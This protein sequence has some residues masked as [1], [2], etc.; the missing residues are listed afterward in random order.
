MR[1]LLT[2]VLLVATGV[3]TTACSS[4]GRGVRPG[5]EVVTTLEVDNQNFTDMTIYLVNGGQ[6]IRLGRATGKSKT[7][8]RLPRN[9][10]TFPRE[11]QFSAEPLG[12]QPGSSTSRIWV[13]P[14]DTVLL[15]ITP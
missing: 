14:G 3:I 6:R 5:S 15:V 12:G 9:V 11:L 7:A 2:L 8:M 13:N 10:L 4:G 1:R